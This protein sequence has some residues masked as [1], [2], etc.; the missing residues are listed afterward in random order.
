MNGHVHGTW[1][2]EGGTLCL[3]PFRPLSTLDQAALE[4]EATRL[5]PFERGKNVSDSSPLATR[6]L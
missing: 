3:T 2:L 4:Q 6:S 5:L 1:S